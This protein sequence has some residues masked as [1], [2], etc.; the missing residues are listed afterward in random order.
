MHIIFSS[1]NYRIKIL[2]LC[3]N[4]LKYLSLLPKTIKVILISGQLISWEE[5]SYEISTLQAWET[6]T[7]ADFV[8][9]KIN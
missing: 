3:N 4:L 2:I 6:W 9:F 7:F 1:V 8:L 5:R